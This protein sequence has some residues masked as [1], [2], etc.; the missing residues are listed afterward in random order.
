MFH[1][2]DDLGSPAVYSRL[3]TRRALPL[4]NNVPLRTSRALWPKTLCSDSTLL[5]LNGTSLNGGNALLAHNWQ[6]HQLRTR[7]TL[8]IF[9]D[10]PLRTRRA[11][12]LYKVYGDGALLVLNGTSSKSDNTLLALNWYV[13]NDTWNKI[14]PTQRQNNNIFFSLFLFAPLCALI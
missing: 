6:Y 7:K 2:W 13:L 14:L 4:F 10:V 12:S 8:S 9:T 5:V 11:L 1:Q 3:R